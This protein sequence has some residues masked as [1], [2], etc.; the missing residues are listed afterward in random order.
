MH[1]QSVA[2]LSVLQWAAWKRGQKPED[3]QIV[4]FF[5]SNVA[6]DAAPPASGPYLHT[7]RVAAWGAIAAAHRKANDE[8]VKLFGAAGA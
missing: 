3:L 6:P 2:P 7:A 5:A 1:L 8:H 4:E